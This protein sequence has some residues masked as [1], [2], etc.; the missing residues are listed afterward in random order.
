MYLPQ[1]IQCYHFHIKNVSGGWSH[2]NPIEINGASSCNSFSRTYG[3]LAGSGPM[4]TEQQS[5]VYS[6]VAWN[7][8]IISQVSNSE[9][10][11]PPAYKCEHFA[12]GKILFFPPWLNEKPANQAVQ[13]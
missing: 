10:G 2:S 12:I 8:C 11:F 6:D 3:S 5:I 9:A 7:A 1:G 4:F 13:W